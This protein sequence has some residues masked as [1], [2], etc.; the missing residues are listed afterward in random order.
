MSV[1]LIKCLQHKRRCPPVKRYITLKHGSGNT[2]HEATF[3][4]F[5][6]SKGDTHKYSY[7]EYD[8]GCVFI[9]HSMLNS[10]L[11]DSL[12]FDRGYIFTNECK[13]FPIFTEPKPTYSMKTITG[14]IKNYFIINYL[15]KERG[16]RDKI[17][18]PY[19]LK[20]YN[21]KNNKYECE[22]LNRW[23]VWHVYP[24]RAF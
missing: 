24:N 18:T 15:N 19:L 9:E 23:D 7:Y 3:Y 14:V 20:V 11:Q 1:R 12:L 21:E 17:H 5:P 22:Q 2:L 8:G 16:M 13:V 10:V 6:I 4:E